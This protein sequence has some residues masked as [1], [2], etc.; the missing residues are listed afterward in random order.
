MPELNLNL[1]FG[2]Q[3]GKF[4]PIF[5]GRVKPE[6]ITLNCSRM[7]TDRL[8][9]HIPTKDDIDVAELSLTGT[10]WGKQ[11]GK[12]WT[13][14]PIFPAW[15]FGC[16][17]ETLVRRDA[18]I[19][20]PEDLRGKRVG[21]P[22]YPVTAIAWIRDA[23][24]KNYGVRREDIRWFEERAPEYSHYRPLGYKPPAGV[25]VE[26]IPKEKRLS[27]MLIAGELDAVTRYFGRAEN[28][29]R[30]EAG[31]RST[32]PLAELAAHPQIRWLYD[33]RKEAAARY[34]KVLGWPQ[35]I[36]CVIVKT[37]IVDKDP[38]VPAR[39]V[40]AFTEA[41]RLA[42]N[43]PGEHS[44]VHA[45]S[46]RLTAAEEAAAIGADFMPVGLRRQNRAA[47]T[48]MLELC[49][50]DGYIDGGKPVTVDEY[51]HPSTLAM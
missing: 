3:P 8:F 1:V 35:P 19:Y 46:Y 5:D 6:G 21:V 17:T 42:P 45:M 51:F 4:Q 44:N 29:N 11:H 38:T 9:W 22:E 26:I 40:R 48:R 24:E 37:E 7:P 47:V 23:F 50:K 18:G 33:D 41:A 43:S 28:A 15:V 16:H 27:E 10:L 12:R 36:H 30:A 31:D 39:L 49:W 14:L 20:R 2:S 32:L 34:C 13:A 25:S